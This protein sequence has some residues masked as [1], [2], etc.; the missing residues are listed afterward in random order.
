MNA[1]TQKESTAVDQRHLGLYHK[2]NVERTDGSSAPGGKHHGD[3]FF[4]LNMTT[5]RHAI[6][7]LRAYAKSCAS[8]YPALAADLRAK[9]RA[10]LPSE[11]AKVPETTLP[12]GLIVPAF[13]VSRFMCTIDDDGKATVLDDGVPTFDISYFDAIKACDAAGVKLI[14][15]TQAL[16]L[17]WNIYNV[18]ANWTGGKVGEGKLFQGLRNGTVDEVQ[19]NDYEPE[20]ADECRWFVLSNGERIYDVAGHLFT[21]VFDDIHGDDQGVVANE[22]AADSISLTTPPHPS[23]EKGIGWRPK[24]TTTS[25]FAAPKQQVSDL[26]SRVAA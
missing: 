1:T 23:M 15:E 19:S 3:E 14:R 7:A 10:L 5:D 21:W 22:F 6:P 11:F 24:A 12:N 2:Y 8:D 25:A 16:A 20:D 17:A 13:Q 18:A 9:I 4:V 26:R